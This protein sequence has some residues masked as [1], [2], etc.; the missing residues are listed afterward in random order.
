MALN[1]QRYIKF[2]GHLNCDKGNR[3]VR[4]GIEVSCILK[5]AVGMPDGATPEKGIDIK[6]DVT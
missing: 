5:L 2:I 1:A 4:E 3:I 6:P